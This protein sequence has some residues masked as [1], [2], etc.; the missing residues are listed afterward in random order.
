MRVSLAEYGAGLPLEALC[1]EPAQLPQLYRSIQQANR[2]LS[3]SLR[4]KREVLQIADD[5][6]R[7]LGIAGVVQLDRGLELE[8]VPKFLGNG[9]DPAWK[10]TLYL[11][12]TLSKH[13]SILTSDR[14]AS[15]TSYLHSLY[16][17]AGRILSQEY[18]RCRRKPIRKYRKEQFREHAIDGEIDLSSVFERHPEGVQ[19]TR[20][21]FDRMNAYNAAIQAAA[22]IVLPYTAD[23]QVRRILSTAAAE[24]G[25]QVPPPRRR[26]SVPARNREWQPAYDLAFDIIQGLGSSYDVGR[27]AAPGFVVDTWQLWQW[28]ITTGLR[29]GSSGHTVVPQ[30]QLLL[31]SRSA[32]GRSAPVYVFPDIEVRSAG[33]AASLYLADAKYK[34]L[35]DTGE[36]ARS[37]LY[38]ALA[39]CRAASAREMVLLYPAGNPSPVPGQVRKC[40]EYAIQDLLIHVVQVSFGAVTGRG[41]IH[42]FSSNLTAG[43]ASI[44]TLP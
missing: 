8:I 23:P 33:A 5:R 16:E 14:I 34:L 2:R 22:R 42:T 40:T 38:E 30:S 11:L 18:L 1:R 7:A 32:G 36:I 27:F 37:D 13:G 9:G 39:F 28:P 43:I 6:L 44:L 35:P 17:I 21:R 41:G 4:V 20:I 29:M 15:S 31:G 26:L 24:L 12:S 3:A 25:E 10:A 19:Q